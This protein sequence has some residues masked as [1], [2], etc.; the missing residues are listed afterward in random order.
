MLNRW[1]FKHIDNSALIVFRFFFGFLLAAEGFGAILT[2]WVKRAFVEP[3][4]TF[5]FIGFDWLQIFVGEYMYAHYAIMG[6]LGVMVMIGYK[7]RFSMFAYA[8]FW[9]ISYFAQ[10]SSYNNHYYLMVLL[11]WAMAFLPAH[12]YASIDARKNPEIVRHSMPRWCGLF[13]ILQVT[14]V[15]VYGTIAKLYPDWLDTT[16]IKIFMQAKEHYYLIGDLLQTQM[17]HYFIAYGGILYDG[18]VIPFLLYKPTRKYAFFA[19]IFFHMFNSIVFQVGVFPYMALAFT[20]FFFEPKTIR[21]IFLKKKPL[22]VDNEV[23]VPQKRGLIVGVLGIYFLIQLALPL[24]HNFIPDKVLWTE[25]GHRLSWRMMLRSKT[26]RTTFEIV[27]KTSGNKWTVKLNDYLTS[28]QKRL[29]NTHPDAIW[30]FAQILKRE[31][32]AKG[33]DVAVHVRASVSV[34]RRPYK[35]LI[36]SDVDLSTVEWNAFKHSDWILPSDLD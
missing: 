26:G 24:R 32:E 10:K 22:Y 1:L 23:K 27:D 8:I 29:I 5:N 4:F 3:Q 19:S 28:K 16:V 2:G 31:Y 30:Q 36:D 6:V 15:Y 33:L 21:N 34:N 17:A 14:C 18:L 13:I 25:E 7:Y 20:V 9:S 35:K 12:R 11:C